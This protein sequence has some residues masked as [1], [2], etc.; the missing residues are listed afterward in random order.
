MKCSSIDNQECK[1]RTKIKSINNNESSFYP[2]SIEANNC[3]GNWNNIYDPY[4][5]SSVSDVAKN[6]NVKMFSSLSGTNEIRH[7][8][9][10]ETCKCQCKLDASVSNNK[11]RW[12]KDK[13]RC[14]Y[15]KLIDKGLC[16][17]GFIWNPISFDYQSD[18]SCDTGEI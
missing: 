14:E 1:S 16:D 7:I 10:H 9:W 2:Y 13:C 3:S 4:S 11:Q 8:K 17:K 6:I 18:K 5:K 15:K 12:N